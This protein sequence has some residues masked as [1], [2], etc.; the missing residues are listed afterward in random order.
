MTPFLWGRE[1]LARL[2]A[3]PA[4]TAPVIGPR[5]L[6]RVLPDED[7]WDLWPVQEPDGSP[8]VIGGRELWMTLSA[9]AVGHP[10]QR[11]DRARL[12]LLSGAGDAWTD[13]GRVFDDGAS[14]GSREWSRS[15]VRRPEG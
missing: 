4:T 3:T 7:V 6:S 2:V 15:A 11:H 14:P 1:H 9:P 10:E 13:L 12:R 5:K 8:S